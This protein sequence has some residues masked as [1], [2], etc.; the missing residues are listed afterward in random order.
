M[1]DFLKGKQDDKEQKSAAE[2]DSD[3]P[4]PSDD[5]DPVEK[6]FGFFFGQ[7]EEAPMGMKRFGR[8]QFPE[9]YPATVDEF[10]EP[11]A[12]DNKDMAIVRPLLKNTNLEFRGLK[13]TY[14]ANRDGWTPEKFH[15]L[16]DKKGGGLVVCTTSDGL[17]CGG[18]NP[19]GKKCRGA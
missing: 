4:P 1:F 11:V 13:L 16:V 10:A 17:V 5:E 9:Q 14:D 8:E 3:S 18:Y 6:I 2:E 12:S 15:N 19:K 7:K